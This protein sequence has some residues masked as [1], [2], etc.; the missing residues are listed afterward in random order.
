MTT[1]VPANNTG[2]SLQLAWTIGDVTLHSITAYRKVDAV[3]ATDLLGSPNISEYSPV[4]VL[5]TAGSHVATEELRADG[6]TL[7]GN[8]HYIGGLYLYDEDAFQ[9]TAVGVFPPLEA[10]NLNVNEQT[11]KSHAVFLHLKYDIT[12]RLHA[13]AGIRKSWTSKDWKYKF[14]HYADILA[15]AGIDPNTQT[16]Q[17]LYT[18]DYNLPN[19]LLGNSTDFVRRSA[20]W[21]PVTPQAGIDFQV[22]PDVLLFADVARGFR[23]GGFNPRATSLGGTAPYAPEYTTSYELGV[24]SEFLDH[25]LRMNATVFYTKYTNLQESILTCVHNASGG[26]QL[27]ASGAP[28]EDHIITNAAAARIAGGELEFAAILGKGFRLD[29]S[30]GY[31]DPKFTSVN[32]SATAAT[33]LSVHS[34][35][36]Q[37]P[38]FTADIAAQHEFDTTRGTVTT[39]VDYTYR[40]TIDFTINRDPGNIQP[41]F[42]LVNATVT[43]KD[44]DSRWKTTLY[45]RNAAD[46][47]YLLSTLGFPEI[48]G[49]PGAL[50]D[51]AD[52]REYGLTIT[53]LFK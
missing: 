42:G 4:P 44:S 20:S 17:I 7:G 22:T 41:G 29:G 49:T 43:F 28:V 13:T 50:Q 19:S 31:T 36:V 27:D 1:D 2:V 3:S 8:L 12:S 21:G 23:S 6:V 33:G 15:D 52:P 16:A 34:A 40:S 51:Y 18:Y 26:C 32:A 45:V 30:A 24:K 46:K 5:E 25:R 35:W 47:K 11:T 9:R 37:V 10:G 39:R 53:R 14:S 38:K 48:F